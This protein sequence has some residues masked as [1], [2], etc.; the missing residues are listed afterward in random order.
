MSAFYLR[1]R[2]D[3]EAAMREGYASMR[4]LPP[5]TH[6]QFEAVVASRDLVLLNDLL[7]TP[8]AELRDL[9]PRAANNSFL[10]LRNYLD[11]G[12]F[13]PDVPGVVPLW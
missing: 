12:T 5:V 2:S 3:L 9:L 13:R 11:T 1:P 10:Q 7:V 4:P 6:D 8:T